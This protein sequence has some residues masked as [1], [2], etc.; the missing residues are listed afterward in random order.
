MLVLQKTG[1]FRQELEGSYISDIAPTRR[2]LKGFLQFLGIN[3]HN[4]VKN[5]PNLKTRAYFMQS[6]MEPDM[7]IISDSKALIFEVWDL[8]TSL[9]QF[10]LKAF[11]KGLIKP[12]D[13]NT[14][15]NFQKQ[16]LIFSGI[17]R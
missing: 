11:C 16:D 1:F 7:K 8:K 5:D 15:F 10:G 14:R 3:T 17:M 6:F 9:G 2:F 12:L 4:V 13:E